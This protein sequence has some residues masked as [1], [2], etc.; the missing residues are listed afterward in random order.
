MAEARREVQTLSNAAALTRIR[1]MEVNDALNKQ[2]ALAETALVAANHAH[3]AALATHAQHATEREKV[4]QLAL[5]EL[6][7]ANTLISDLRKTGECPVWVPRF[8]V[9]R[10]LP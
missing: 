5:S 10:I 7:Q 6:R 4:Y 2:C 3:I 8:F 1:N 9:Q